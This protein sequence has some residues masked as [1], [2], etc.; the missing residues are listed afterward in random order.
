MLRDV[1]AYRERLA[2]GAAAG[3]V[4]DDLLTTGYAHALELEAE[5][6]SYDKALD[7][8]LARGDEQGVA[9]VMRCRRA[10]TNAGNRLRDTLATARPRRAAGSPP[11]GLPPATS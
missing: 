9:A 11:P 2:S 1:E 4:T 7:T 3:E 6:A 8:L 10:L 5:S